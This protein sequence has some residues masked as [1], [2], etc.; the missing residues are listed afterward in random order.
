LL[1][2]WFCACHCDE[3]K[4]A[5]APD[6]AVAQ[7]SLADQLSLPAGP[8]RVDLEPVGLGATIAAAKGTAVEP[9]ENGGGQLDVGG[10]MVRVRAAKPG[11]PETFPNWWPQQQPIQP[12]MKL[13]DDDGWLIVANVE[14]PTAGRKV[15]AWRARAGTICESDATSD[16]RL[17]SEAVRA[18]ISL[19]AK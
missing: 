18:C 7:K 13:A 1:I 11:A 6:A 17:A 4:P 3:A 12:M 9:R 10:V 8:D 14:G 15:I 5:I 2:F 16:R 19:L